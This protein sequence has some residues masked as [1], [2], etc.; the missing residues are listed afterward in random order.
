MVFPKTTRPIR[1]YFGIGITLWIQTMVKR[2]FYFLFILILSGI[3][4][5]EVNLSE[6]RKED[7]ELQVPSEKMLTLEQTIA[8]ALKYNRS[9]KDSGLEIQLQEAH[10]NGAKDALDP[11]LKIQPYTR[12]ENN[13]IQSQTQ[14]LNN[15]FQTQNHGLS[16]IASLKL[17]AGTQLSATWTD[18]QIITHQPITNGERQSTQSTHFQQG[19]ELRLVQPLTKG[20]GSEIN[21]APIQQAAQQQ[22]IKQLQLQQQQMAI[23]TNVVLTYRRL[24]QA[25]KQVD[26]SEQALQ[27]TRELS[28]LSRS[29]V[30]AGRLP[31]AEMIQSEAETSLKELEVL[32]AKNQFQ[33]R[34]FDL[35]RIL[36]LPQWFQIFPVEIPLP[37][38]VLLNQDQLLQESLE[39]RPDYAAAKILLQMAELELITAQNNRLWQLD[40]DANYLLGASDTAHPQN[41]TATEMESR[42]NGWSLGLTLTHIFGD[43]ILEET[44]QTSRLNQL[45]AIESLKELEDTIRLEVLD[46]IREI[47]TSE[48]QWILAKKARELS[49]KKLEIEQEKLKLGRSSNFQMIRFQ[50]DLDNAFQ[51]ELGAVIAYHN[52]LTLLDQTTGKTLQHWNLASLF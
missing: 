2:N 24:W 43:G 48:Q 44:Y 3:A 11:H 16:A 7:P 12:I 6:P 22:K 27:K 19:L 30:E 15:E 41:L 4:R 52:A 51:N 38:S 17:A 39:Q 37:T 1:F 8:L 20:A 47:Y 28:V 40:F 46:R 33:S 45:R 14:T 25:L 29:L 13:R 18:E 50:E 21:R 49:E 36:D 32:S 26:L 5:A 31:K 10:L 35:L 42:K 9:L 34:Q 23:V